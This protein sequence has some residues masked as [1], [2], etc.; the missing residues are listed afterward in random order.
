MIAEEK[1]IKD[2]NYIRKKIHALL[3]LYTDDNVLTYR[4]KDTK[5]QLEK[6]IELIDK[7]IDKTN[8]VLYQL[9]KPFLPIIDELKEEIEFNKN[10]LKPIKTD[11]KP[12]NEKVYSKLNYL[13]R[14]NGLLKEE[15][16]R[17]YYNNYDNLQK[18]YEIFLELIN[19]LNDSGLGII[20]EKTLFSAYLG[21]SVE[22]Y[23]D[24]LKNASDNNVRNL[25]KNI[26]E[27]FTT[28]QFGA[29]INNDRKAIERIQKTETYGQEMRQTQPENLNIINNN[30]LSFS[31]LLQEIENKK[32]QSSIDT[33]KIIDYKA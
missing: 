8:D 5:E 12:Y 7:Y 18:K 24:L 26:D 15:E 25:F 32:Q 29:L 27:Y 19:W 3:K 30:Q 9:K 28:N 11:V 6:L 1:E 33:N 16:A 14:K 4:D 23:N 22:M 2:I 31:D 20:P 21:I 13:F 10:Q 17:V